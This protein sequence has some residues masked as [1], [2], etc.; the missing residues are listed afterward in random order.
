[1][2]PLRGSNT[3]MGNSAIEWIEIFFSESLDSEM[4]SLGSKRDHTYVRVGVTETNRLLS[5]RQIFNKESSGNT[6]AKV[7]RLSGLHERF[8]TRPWVDREYKGSTRDEDFGTQS[9]RRSNI[10]MLESEHDAIYRESTRERQILCISGV[11]R[12]RTDR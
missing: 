2:A 3:G 7:A 1:M 9:F 10:D 5:G 4:T 11:L 12:I 6:A 8:S